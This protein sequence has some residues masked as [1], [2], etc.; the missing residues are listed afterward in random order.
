M[1]FGGNQAGIIYACL[2]SQD[3]KFLAEAGDKSS[4][5][6]TLQAFISG[7][8]TDPRDKA[9]FNHG[10]YTYNFLKD[11]GYTFI[12]VAPS[13]VES[14]VVFAFLNE[15]IH[16]FNTGSDRS[17]YTGK[18]N[19]LLV[20]YQNPQR[21]DLISMMNQDLQDTKERMHQN[22]DDIIR[23]G[24]TIDQIEQNAESMEHNAHEMVERSTRVKEI[25]WWKRLKVILFHFPFCRLF[26]SLF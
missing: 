21:Q 11:N 12:A 13:K 25:V 14:R 24:I 6:S 18:I 16:E 1:S 17:N 22:L 10:P 9:A 3:Q 8:A 19:N 5:K 4:V 23:R 7:V 26:I 20:K 15:M 2:C